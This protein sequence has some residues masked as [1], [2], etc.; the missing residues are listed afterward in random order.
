MMGWETFEIPKFQQKFKNS[1]CFL[2]NDPK[3]QKFRK[4]IAEVAE[5]A[6][7]ADGTVAR[8]YTKFEHLER[9]ERSW[10]KK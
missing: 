1:N 8:G 5:V 10:M 7:V 3:I 6:E 4:G 9:F 2:G